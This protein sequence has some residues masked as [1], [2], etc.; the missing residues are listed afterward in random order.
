MGEEEKERGKR[1]GREIYMYLPNYD[2]L[3]HT[4]TH[5][6]DVSVWRIHWL[7][8]VL[9]HKEDHLSEVIPLRI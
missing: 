3:S 1:G 7:R 9:K 2:V 6:D 8:T 5:F 4:H